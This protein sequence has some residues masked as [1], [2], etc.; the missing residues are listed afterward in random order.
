MTRLLVVDD[1]P[2]NREILE[3][4]LARRGYEIVVASNGREALER[5]RA[6]RPDAVVMDLSMPV[7]DGYATARA[8]RA[9]EDRA[10]ART[11]LIALT[12]HVL[13]DERQRAIEAGFDE[14]ESK[15]VDLERLVEKLAAALRGRR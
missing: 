10:V 8:V 5:I 9:D 13:S 4:R 6:D 3:R 1:D 7:L 12:A 11:P 2:V 15:P 14:Y